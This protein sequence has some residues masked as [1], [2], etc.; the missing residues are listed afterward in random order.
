MKLAVNAQ[1]SAQ[2]AIWA[3]TLVVLAGAGI[4]T[5][6]AVEVLNTLPTTSPALQIGGALMAAAQYMPLF[7]IDLVQKDL[8]YARTLAQELGIPTPTLDAVY[9]L[10][11]DANARGYGND[12]IVGVKQVIDASVLSHKP[13]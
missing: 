7:P 5:A 10:Y 4:E 2:V 9:G 6:Q 1:Y 12:N 8:G 11:A 13:H 3:E